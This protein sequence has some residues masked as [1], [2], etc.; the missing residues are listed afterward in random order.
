MMAASL[1]GGA[2]A[3]VIAVLIL[4]LCSVAISTGV[5]GQD[6]ELQMVIAACVLGGFCGGRVTGR[7]WG[8]RSL[9]AGLSAGGVLLLILLTVGLLAYESVMDWDGASLG[10]MAGCLC[11]GLAAGLLGSRGGKKKKRTY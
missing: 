6:L 9:L 10:V 2:V 7:K 11:G 8:R 4:L 5:V 3:A 1:L